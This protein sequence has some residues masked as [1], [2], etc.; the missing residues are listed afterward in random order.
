MAYAGAYDDLLSALDAW[1]ACED[2]GHCGIMADAA[3]EIRRL[4]GLLR[5][6]ETIRTDEANAQ[7]VGPLRDAVLEMVGKLDGN[8]RYVAIDVL[9]EA[10]MLLME[11][12]DA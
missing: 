2:G 9:N 4:R 8:M 1:A 6:V 10:L 12:T 7:Q 3:A 11:K 5:E